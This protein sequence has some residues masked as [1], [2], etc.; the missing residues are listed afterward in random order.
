[1]TTGR[2]CRV[3][4]LVLGAC[5]AIGCGGAKAGDSGCEVCKSGC[6]GGLVT[7]CLVLDPPGCG[8]QTAVGF[9]PYGCTP[10][11]PEL[12]NFYPVDGAVSSGCIA[13]SATIQQGMLQT[14]GV[15]T[16]TT[17]F[18]SSGPQVIIA[19]SAGAA[20]KTSAVDGGVS[21]D[22]N[23]A[24]LALLVPPMSAGTFVVGASHAIAEPMVA[25]ND[26]GVAMFDLGGSAAQLTVWKTGSLVPDT[27]Y[28]TSGSVVVNESDPIGGLMGSYDLAFGTEV[29][30]G[31]FI[32]PACDPCV[33]PFRAADSPSP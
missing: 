18:L 7:M 20:C 16:A 17:S 2:Q 33:G 26:A 22:E 5:I 15:P 27:S 28:A 4:V 3:L 6:G 19:T 10:N 1:V 13:S 30:R 31:T 23:G 12:C 9:C 24:V 14:S 8:A 11:G 32:A 21:S 29:E 25:K